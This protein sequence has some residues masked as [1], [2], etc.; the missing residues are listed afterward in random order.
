MDH[1]KVGGIV[2]VKGRVQQN[3]AATKA[4]PANGS[5]SSSRVLD[6]V[7][8]E[9]TLLHKNRDVLSKA[10]RGAQRQGAT[11]VKTAAQLLQ[12]QQQQ[13]TNGVKS[14]S[15][16]KFQKSGI[17]SHGIDSSSSS[18]N[19]ASYE[20]SRTAGSSSSN[21]RPPRSKSAPAQQPQPAL[22]SSSVAAAAGAADDAAGN[23]YWQLPA[24]IASS[25][26]W[27]CDEQGIATMQQLVLP[28]PSNET[29]SSSGNGVPDV[30]VGLD[31]EWR[32]YE[33][34]SP[35]TPVALLQLATRQHVF[36]VDL[37]AICQQQQQQQPGP[38][39]ENTSSSDG[40]NSR[41]EQANSSSSSSS[42]RS[43]V[44]PA[45]GALSRFLLSLLCDPRVVKV[46]FQLGTDL[47]RL[48]VSTTQ[49]VVVTLELPAVVVLI[50][51]Q[52]CLSSATMSAATCLHTVQWATPCVHDSC[53][54]MLT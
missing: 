28:E 21:G 12:L 37:L 20:T 31:C 41:C 35:A 1:I 48:Q 45:E 27:V 29:S 10:V 43:R 15:E 22:G 42:S 5:S 33:K 52:C 19:A 13:G 8:Q 4:Q 54:R 11:D 32:P 16:L 53:G 2:L 49:F 38:C 51:K 34:N 23:K 47:A 6:V 44:S 50:S 7:A 40:G 30:V 3:P 17:G 18:R 9:V 14:M 26:H 36:L 25:I 24:H 46:G 39:S